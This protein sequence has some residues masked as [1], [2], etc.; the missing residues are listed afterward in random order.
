MKSVLNY[1]WIP[2]KDY[3]DSSLFES[4]SPIPAEYLNN[5]VRV[6]RDHPDM[7]VWIWCDYELLREDE[8]AFL[9]N[10]RGLP[11][12]IHFKDMN[13]IV[14]YREEKKK[15]KKGVKT[16]QK[17]SA[18]KKV[19]LAR[20]LVLEHV[21]K[22]TGANE[23]FYSDLDVINPAF[24]SEHLKKRGIVFC[25][26]DHDGHERRKF[27]EN[28]FLGLHRKWA[29]FLSKNF[30]PE[31]RKGYQEGQKDGWFAFKAC[32][33]KLCSGQLKGMDPETLSFTLRTFWD[34]QDPHFRPEAPLVL[35]SSLLRPEPN[36]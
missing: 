22:R 17:S 2:N 25:C 34:G 9:G 26:Y 32:A 14:A 4:R 18:W 35:Q 23:V 6:A 15:K 27:L 21:F 19:D 16:G 36:G 33:K 29:D 7:T 30:I 24:E 10:L 28:G 1:V 5:A 8:K 20:L 12:N 31:T 3:Y 11:E 13:D